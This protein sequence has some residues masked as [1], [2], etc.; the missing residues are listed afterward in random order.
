MMVFQSKYLASFKALGIDDN[1][2][3]KYHFMLERLNSPADLKFIDGVL[4]RFIEVFQGDWLKNFQTWPDFCDEIYNDLNAAEEL[5]EIIANHKDKTR[6]QNHQ[7]SKN[8]KTVSALRKIF[9]GYLEAYPRYPLF[10]L[11]NQQHPKF[12]DWVFQII[13]MAPKCFEGETDKNLIWSK[14]DEKSTC[15]FFREM[16]HSLDAIDWLY[17]ETKAECKNLR[18][19]IRL[20]STSYLK[21]L[22]DLIEVRQ[23]ER[24]KLMRQRQLEQ[25]KQTIRN[26]EM[27][28]G[29]EFKIRRRNRGNRGPIPHITDTSQVNSGGVTALNLDLIL[30][31]ESFPLFLEFTDPSDA[32]NCSSSPALYSIV[33]DRI[34]PEHTVAGETRFELES[35][36]MY[37]FAEYGDYEDYVIAFHARRL[38]KAAINRMERQ[39]QYIPSDSTLLNNSQL[40]GILSEL[41]KPA[42]NITES[43][44]MTFLLIL[45]FFTATPITELDAARFSFVGTELGGCIER[46]TFKI[47]YQTDQMEN[48]PAPRLRLPIPEYLAKSFLCWSDVPNYE[49]QY[50]QSLVQYKND[51]LI[52]FEL[53]LLP[54]ATYF[55]HQYQNLSL[56]RLSNHLFLTACQ[57]FGSATASLMF[58]RPAPGSQARL[59]YTSLSE[60]ILQTRYLQLCAKVGAD[61]G[62]AI[63]MF[64][65]LQQPKN[66]ELRIGCRPPPPITRYQKFLIQLKK[67][68]R[69]R[70]KLLLEGT[71]ASLHRLT[72]FHNIYTVYCIIAQ[73]LLTAIRPTH[74][75]FIPLSKI[76]TDAEI[77]IIRDKDSDDEFHTRTIPIHP[78]AL[79]IAQQYDRHI[80][81]MKAKLI[82]LGLFNSWVKR[83]SPEPFFFGEDRRNGIPNV[84][85]YRPSLL[86]KYSQH[87]LNE[88]PNSN[89]RILRSWLEHRNVQFQVIDA[90]MGHGNLGE[91]G[92]HAHST[93]SFSDIKQQLMPHLDEIAEIFA[94]EAV[95]GIQ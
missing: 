43:R 76:L 20:L 39:H 3:K 92:W 60:P 56:V 78:L 26:L 66:D 17:F 13:Y 47:Q 34:T 81:E 40:Y 75:G 63:P 49:K 61:A 80:M 7:L 44:D 5:I 25:L 57:M 54:I 72:D 46:N 86:L 2:I 77:A 82:R 30:Q 90:F 16:T 71:D 73:A 45:S 68:V 32:V 8:L 62:F 41:N 87:L 19:F 79:K 22:S 28:L 11:V 70:R 74:E 35:A 67:D 6:F 53:D 88:R 12:Y 4:K 85:P 52:E 84:Q 33:E 14:H 64:Q 50:G 18:D 21:Y 1:E 58:A 42:T 83:D 91:H 24:K 27:L 15:R 51:Q 29:L 93:L 48:S 69:K 36:N 9:Y 10:Y 95:Q 38:G 23:F 65:N 55:R 94:I 59:Y 31:L 37:V 89:R